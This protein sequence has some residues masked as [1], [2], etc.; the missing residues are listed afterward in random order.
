MYCVYLTTYFGNKLPPFY[1]GSASIDR[2]SKGYR[3][4]VSSKRYKSIWKQE[5]ADN[6][7]LFRTRIICQFASR[8]EA[9]EKEKKLQMLLNVVPNN[10]YI[11]QALACPNGFFGRDTKGENNPM[12]GRT[13][14][15]ESREKM[16]N[17]KRGKLISDSHKQNISNYQNSYWSS[18]KSD[19]DRNERRKKFSGAGNPQYGKLGED[20]PRFG[21][22][23]SEETKERMRFAALNRERSFEHS[24]NLSKIYKIECERTGMIFIGFGLSNFCKAIGA[25]TTS[26]MYTLKTKK[27]MSGFRLLE[28]LGFNQDVN[29]SLSSFILH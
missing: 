3:G 15:D 10:M 9:L 18:N 29:R 7:Q 8:K 25:K 23:H 27:F 17:A 28:N 24:K 12:F 14:S 13:F 5:L 16:A 21:Q 26:F 19:S 6:P 2:I 20:N 4:T 11:N 1:I 22:K